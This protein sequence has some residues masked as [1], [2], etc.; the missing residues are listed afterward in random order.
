MQV[1]SNKSSLNFFLS[2]L[3]LFG[4]SHFQKKVST[5]INIFHFNFFFQ[6]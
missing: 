6:F 1:A 2:S 3:I 4:L 5:K